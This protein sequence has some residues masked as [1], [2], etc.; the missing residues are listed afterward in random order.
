ML[1]DLRESGCL[2]GDSRVYLPESGEYRPIA[3][4]VGR[5]GFEVEALNT[6][7][8]KLERRRVTRAFATGRKQVYRLTTQLG[9]TIRASGNHKFLTFT[10]WNRLDEVAVGDRLALPRTLSGPS[11]ST[12]STDELA[13]LG[14]LI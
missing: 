4:L 8:W 7:T 10:G 12:M 9:R 13:L 2:T 1:S 14:H 6:E 3:E 5:S 11:R